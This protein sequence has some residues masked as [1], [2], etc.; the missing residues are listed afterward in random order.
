MIDF[1]GLANITSDEL[2]ALSSQEISALLGFSQ[3]PKYPSQ[4]INLDRFSESEEMIAA[5]TYVYAQL[6][7]EG[8]LG[9]YR[10]TG[11]KNHLNIILSNLRH[12]DYVFPR[13]WLRYSRVKAYYSKIGFYYS[14]GSSCTYLVAVIDGLESIGLVEG[15]RGFKNP[16]TGIG[17]QSRIR[18]KPALLDIFDYFGVTPDKVT[19]RPKQKLIQLKDTDGK[20]IEY[21]DTEQTIEMHRQ[22]VAYNELLARADIELHIPESDLESALALK[23]NP[24]DQSAKYYH[25]VFREGSFE[26]LGRFYGP[27]W[28][29]LSSDLRSHI[30]IN[31]RETTELDYS[32]LHVH[33]LYSEMKLHYWDLFDPLDD[34]Y[35]L[36]G[37]CTKSRDVLKKAFLIWLN[38]TNRHTAD[39]AII[40]KLMELG[41][42]EKGMDLDGTFDGFTTKHPAIS[43]YLLAGQGLHFQYLDS[44][45]TE[46]IVSWSI[47]FGIPILGIHDSFI[48]SRPKKF[49]LKQI[50]KYAFVE[51]NL[52][53]I[54]KIKTVY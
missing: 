25:R 36:S 28:Q 10:E 23:V 11:F 18:P 15:I 31:N 46:R 26:H 22:L 30:L 52:K 5:V 49:L 48:V 37:Y 41:I 39:K 47:K 43:D 6:Q 3:T 29:N 19:S 21:E 2:N 45:I 33:L 8:V 32:A 42:Y 34:P 14:F 53:S 20:L 51:R 40:D 44:L 1:F 54:P 17:K 38:N 4:L 35:M 27:W 9:S 16:K 24:I 7:K 50:M 13:Y 12:V